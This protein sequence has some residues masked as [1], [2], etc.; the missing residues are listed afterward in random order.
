MHVA[1]QRK[2]PILIVKNI[3]L[4]KSIVLLK[5]AFRH[6]FQSHSCGLGMPPTTLTCAARLLSASVFC[7]V[8]SG[9]GDDYGGR[10]EVSGV[11]TLK[12]QPL[13]QGSI[14]FMPL[15]ESANQG[16]VTQSGAVITEGK[17]HIP[18]EQGL[19]PGDYQVSISSA[20]GLTPA[21]PDAPP[22]P[23]G[24]T[25]TKDRIPP[26][27]NVNSKQKVQVKE[28]EPNSFDFSIP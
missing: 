19:V 5:S 14:S 8:A 26:E 13:D 15:G 22:G 7:L 3:F 23:T 20:D 6:I 9:C 27:F 10:Q 18:A 24:N 25:V 11:I 2:W 12:G 17:Y 21:D 1:R 28:G 4:T 16:M